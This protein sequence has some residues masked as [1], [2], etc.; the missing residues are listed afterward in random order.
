MKRIIF[1][2]VI[3][4]IG[5]NYSCKKEDNI[6]FLQDLTN[7][8][9]WK[10][11]SIENNSNSDILYI[12]ESVREM[13]LEFTDS[14]I[15]RIYSCCNSG[16]GYYSNSNYGGLA[17]DISGMTKMFCGTVV[18]DWEDIYIDN[19]NLSEKYNIVGDKLIIHTTGD[20]DLN[21]H[22]KK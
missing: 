22:L 19:L 18:M 3:C 15:V 12:P 4:C 9:N 17:I 2:M 7:E 8:N 14:S 11:V 1:L 5:L 6:D 10:L 20:Y 21:F 13:Y 16:F